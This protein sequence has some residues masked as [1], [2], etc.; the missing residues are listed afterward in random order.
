MS[1][2][3]NEDSNLS[4]RSSRRTEDEHEDTSSP[5][6]DWLH[7]SACARTTG[8]TF[9]H[10]AEARRENN[11]A[12]LGPNSGDTDEASG[13]LRE[14]TMRSGSNDGADNDD[15][16]FST[17]LIVP[18][19]SLS[20]ALSAVMI[21]APV[22][23]DQVAEGLIAEELVDEA[24]VIEGPTVETPVTER[25]EAE[26]STP[27][28][29]VVEDTVEEKVVAEPP[30]VEE[31]EASSEK[32]NEDSCA[33]A[34][35]K[36]PK[37]G[38]TD[39]KDA[40]VEAKTIELA[41]DAYTSKNNGAESGVTTRDSECGGRESSGNGGVTDTALAEAVD[42]VKENQDNNDLSATP[43][44]DTAANGD[45]GTADLSPADASSEAAA[46]ASLTVAVTAVSPTNGAQQEVGDLKE[47]EEEVR[48]E[49]N[50]GSDVDNTAAASADL[51]S[52]SAM[53][54]LLTSCGLSATTCSELE[55]L[56]CESLTECSALTDEELEAVIHIDMFQRAR[57]NM[58]YQSP[59][60]IAML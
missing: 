34:I 9:D 14:E 47:E 24:A 19:E 6:G 57:D 54:D 36:T 44:V 5:E 41:E 27:D 29:P 43:T 21:E 46:A 28:E 11:Y 8:S 35:I 45:D 58:K 13:G 56:G 7:H 51:A 59:N 15:A 1:D 32:P 52:V 53:R 23:D 12:A 3:G 33:S 22:T 55:A 25:P 30:V 18:E 20:P 42:E 26:A 49:G 38:A 2:E 39:V 4:Y 60:L 50:E 48:C 16:L 10:D 40:N 31:M 37:H 17:E